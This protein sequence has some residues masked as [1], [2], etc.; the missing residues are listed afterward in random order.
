MPKHSLLARAASPAI[1][2]AS[3]P[4]PYDN[5]PPATPVFWLHCRKLDCRVG[6][7]PAPGINHHQPQIGLKRVVM[8]RFGPSAPTL[9]TQRTPAS[10]KVSPAQIR[11]RTPSPG[12]TFFGKL[13]RSTS[14]GTQRA[15]VVVFFDAP[16]SPLPSSYSHGLQRSLRRLRRRQ[17][18]RTTARLHGA[19]N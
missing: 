15:S 9:S 5:S 4:P 13:S 12:L 3:P 14:G 6:P 19:N 18:H 17:A 2:A 16:T 1:P 7:P 8:N 10:Q 11:R